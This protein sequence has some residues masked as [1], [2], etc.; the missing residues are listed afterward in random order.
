MLSAK[1]EKALNEQINA[2]FYSAY[3]YLSMSAHFLS[4][5]LKGFA[6][7][8]NAQA[9]EEAVHAMKIYNFILDRGGKVKLGPIDGPQS[10]WD[11]PLAVFEAAYKHEQY[12]TSL[13][14]DLVAL[15]VDE[16]DY[17]TKNLMDWFVDE[18]V[19]E[20]AS[21][22]EIVEQLKLIGGEGQGLL[23]LDREMAQRELED[24]E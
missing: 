10:A 17:A 9:R 19:E 24:E 20:E 5:D 21:A 12:V 23:M 14:Y 16:K 11:S 15:A 8:M 7:W 22:S 4:I 18:Q 1:M 2:E 6:N 3:I 13:I